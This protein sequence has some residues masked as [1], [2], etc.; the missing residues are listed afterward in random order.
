MVLN[1]AA[2][3][4]GAAVAAAIAAQQRK[5]LQKIED[6]HARSE[7]SAVH[8]VPENKAEA[9]HL[10]SL[11]TQRLI[12]ETADG[13]IYLTDKAKRSLSKEPASGGAVML[14]LLGTLVLIASVVA[15]LVV[16]TD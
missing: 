13:K 6:L 16:F 8:F 11:K 1:A 10:K 3:A 5:L 15:L 7:G 9:G 12:A 4:A 2:G 14:V